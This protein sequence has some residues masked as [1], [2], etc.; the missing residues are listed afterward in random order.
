MVEQITHQRHLGAAVDVTVY[1]TGKTAHWVKIETVA[2]GRLLEKR[3]FVRNGRRAAENW[4]VAM[5][6]LLEKRAKFNPD[7]ET[8]YY[9]QQKER[10]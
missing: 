10:P 6:D 4:A 8:R 9:P 7:W 2:T 5:F 1:H 3:K